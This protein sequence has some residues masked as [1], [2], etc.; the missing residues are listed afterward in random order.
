MSLAD[1]VIAGLTE[2]VKHAAGEDVP[3]MVVHVPPTL[4][5]SAIRAKTALSQPA[6]ASSVGVSLGTLRQWEQKRRTPEG[7]A[8]V[9]LAMV[10]QRPRIVMET[11]GVPVVTATPSRGPKEE[12]SEMGHAL[13]LGTT[14][15]RTKS[16]PRADVPTGTCRESRVKRG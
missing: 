6:F 8:R 10:D 13:E 3:G 12:L 4:D 16:R 5:V 7:P 15:R 1:R 2:A 9:L 14:R 11:L